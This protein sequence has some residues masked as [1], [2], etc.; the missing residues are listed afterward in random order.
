MCRIDQRFFWQ[1]K[2]LSMNGIVEQPGIALLE[3]SSAAASNEQCVASEHG[4]AFREVV[5]YATGCVSGRGEH[6]ERDAIATGDLI[7]VGD[8]HVGL[9]TADLGDDALYVRE[10][11][12]YF[13]TSGY[14]IGVDVSVGD[15]LELKG[16]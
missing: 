2:N 13:A 15:V 9:G 7:T 8:V 12:L 11:L 10:T 14:V 6:L 5:G 3:V 1:C 16:R 4:L